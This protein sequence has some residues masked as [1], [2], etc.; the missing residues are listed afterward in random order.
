M[1]LP[2]TFRPLA[3]L[4]HC[5]GVATGPDGALWAGD[6]QGVIFRVDPADGAVERVADKISGLMFHVNC[7]NADFRAFSSILDQIGREYEPLLRKM[8]WV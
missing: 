8:E 6:E 5:E 4:A 1:A 3:H 2:P 7:E